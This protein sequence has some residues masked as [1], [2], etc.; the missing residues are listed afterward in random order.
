MLVVGDVG[1]TKIDL[2]VIDPAVG[3]RHP[4]ARNQLPSNRYPSLDA[5]VREF[6]ADLDLPVDRGC[7]AVAGPVLN[8]RVRTTNLPWEIEERALADALGL[9]SVALLNDLEAIARAVPVLHGEDLHPI[10]PGEAMAGGAIGVVAPGTGLGEAFLTWDGTRYRAHASEGGHADFAPTT[11]LQSDLLRWMHARFD[12]ASYEM[13][14]SGVGIP[15]LYDFLRDRREVPE[16]PDL[17]QQLAAA[18]DRTRLIVMAGLDPDL[19]DP[20]SAATLALF[21]EILAAEAGNLALKVL[22]TGGIY[23][24]GGLAV[25]T[26]ALLEGPDFAAAFRRKGRFTNLVSR[27]PV[28][29]VLAPAALIGA[30][31]R[32]L[33]SPDR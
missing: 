17:A 33:E 6:L 25:R 9:K 27:V 20:L 2:A 32:G 7:F 23:L 26:L 14:C 16:S 30:A 4:V 8:G 24:A 31:S 13:V 15:H 10:H 3:P 21:V 19:P 5:A 1:G 28:Q 29:V 11:T 12:H 22:A 18:P